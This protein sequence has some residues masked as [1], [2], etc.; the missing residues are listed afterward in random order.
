[1]WY[2]AG[3]FDSEVRRG[4]P[5]S[6]FLGEINSNSTQFPVWIL[7][8]SFFFLECL[9]NIR[10]NFADRGII[11]IMLICVCKNII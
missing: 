2:I 8:F 4:R 1:M 7:L 5:C 11:L 10:R 6:I 3:Y 9:R